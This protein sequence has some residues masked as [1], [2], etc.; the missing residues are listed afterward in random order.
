MSVFRI[1]K[2]KN[3]T[4]MSNYHFQDKTISLKAKGLLSLM[5]SL[6]EDWDFTLNGLVK[7]SSDGI[8]AV[9]SAVKELEKHGY[10]ERERTRNASGQFDDIEYIIRE[11]PIFSEPITEEPT[12]KN[13]SK[14][15]PIT[16]KDTQLNTNKSKTNKSRT[17]EIKNP[18]IKSDVIDEIDSLNYTEQVKEQICYDSLC[19]RHGKARTDEIVDLM[20]EMFCTKSN[21]IKVAGDEY[22]AEMVKNRI[23]RLDSASIEYIFECIDKNTKKIRN[24]KNYLKTALY[25]AP[26][27]VDTYYRTEVNHDLWGGDADE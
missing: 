12:A 18:S 5:L 17:D 22:P 15:N 10:L 7:I 24:I 23:L 11:K 2:T 13:P 8:G 6:P 1:E 20:L 14:D 19:Q 21:N 4:I 9:S 27:T 25:N 16:P 3:F 26:A